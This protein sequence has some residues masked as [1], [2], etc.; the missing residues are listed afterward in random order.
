MEGKPNHSEKQKTKWESLA[1]GPS[2]EELSVDT[3]E[4]VDIEASLEDGEE[5]ASPE[6]VRKFLERFWQQKKAEAPGFAEQQAEEIKILNGQFIKR[7]KAI[8]AEGGEM[9]EKEF[10]V[11]ERDYA[12]N[13]KRLQGHL[14]DGELYSM[15]DEAEVE[16]EMFFTK[17]ESVLHE[18]IEAQA[19]TYYRE[20]AKALREAIMAGNDPKKEEELK[21]LS[22]FYTA[23]NSH[24]D[25]KYMTPQDIRYEYAG[26]WGEYD[27][28][29]TYAHNN[30]ITHLNRMNDLARKYGTTPFTPRQF[31]TSEKRNQTPAVSKRMR[32]DRDVVEEYYAIAFS[33]EVARRDRKLER[34]L[35]GY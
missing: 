23:V 16:G 30:A 1:D 4:Q 7:R 32:Y 3:A 2:P 20:R 29:R 31:W 11:W 10:L 35:R 14:R 5:T 26:N 27:R 17:E 19:G 25:Y 15:E 28:D 22:G 34:D 6:W 9:S 8:K 12:D 33:D 13:W 18:T 21:I 24:L